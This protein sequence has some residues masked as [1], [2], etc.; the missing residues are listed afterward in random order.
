MVKKSLAIGMPVDL[1]TLPPICE[2]CVAA[3]QMKTPVPKTRGGEQAKRQLEKV[4]SDI[5]GPEDVSTPYGDKYMLN[6]IDDYSGMAWIYPLKKKMD[7]FN[8]F[9]EWK[10]L[11][12]M[13][14]VNT[15]SCFIQTMEA[16]T[17][18]TLFPSTCAAKGY[19]IKL[20]HHT[21]PLRMENLKACT[22]L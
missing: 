19:I 5:A 20:L 9:Q 4:H 21:H 17:H 2:H 3:K 11:L 15:S 7:T 14:P 1:S 22:G 10:A 18:L 8:F 13:K 12:R 6:L 16:S